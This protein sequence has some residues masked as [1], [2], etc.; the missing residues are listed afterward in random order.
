MP[1]IFDQPLYGFRFVDTRYGDTLQEIALRE[2][3]DAA[4]WPEL[5]SYN[6]LVP[7]FFVNDEADRAPGVAVA[8][9]MLLVPAPAPAADTTVPDE[10]FGTDVLLGKDGMLQFEGGD[11]A[12]VSGIDNYKQ[13]LQNAIRTARG[14][15]IFYPRYGTLIPRLIGTV[16]GPTAGLLAAQYARS[17]VAADSR[18]RRVTSATAEVS[19][20]VVRVRVVAEGKNGQTANVS[21]TL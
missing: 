15:L 7:P 14:E 13:A 12:T 5:I 21:P 9:D 2:L 19:G 10:V 1:T 11:L 4:R 3:G 17:T 6:K 18:T 16:N 8:G 20:D